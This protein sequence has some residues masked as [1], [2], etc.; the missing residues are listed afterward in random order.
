MLFRKILFKS[1]LPDFRVK[2]VAVLIIN[3]QKPAH[4]V[5]AGNDFPAAF[6]NVFHAQLL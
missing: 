5:D 4:I 1:P 2:V 3:F 6:Q